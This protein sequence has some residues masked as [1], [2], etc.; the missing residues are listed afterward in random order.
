MSSKPEPLQT[1]NIKPAT[2]LNTQFK[3]RNK[4]LYRP[5]KPN[6][7]NPCQTIPAETLKPTILAWNFATK[8][9]STKTCQSNQKRNRHTQAFRTNPRPSANI[10]H[11][12][13]KHSKQVYSGI[14]RS[15]RLRQQVHIST[16][17]SFKGT[18]VEEVK[19]W[20]VSRGF[21][22]LKSSSKP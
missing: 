17:K 11:W 6:N 16:G 5:V 4:S 15:K 21:F 1:H 13:I 3:R 20:I 7:Q 10:H 8:N 2:K 14:L 22:Q 12:A 9:Q 18:E 19:K